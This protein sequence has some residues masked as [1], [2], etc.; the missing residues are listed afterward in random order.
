MKVII[1]R[2]A[3]TV[4]NS[5][6]IHI[7]NDTDPL[8][9]EEGKKQAEKL[10]HLLKTEKIHFAYVSPQKRAVHTAE[11]VLKFHPWAKM[12]QM[13]HLRE[14]RLGIYESLPKHEWKKIKENTKDPFHLFKPPQ[15]ESYTEL[16]ARVAE[17]FNDLVNKHENDTVFIVSHR[18][19]LGMLYLHLFNK[20]ITEDNYNAHKPENTALT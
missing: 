8:L 3:E 14:Q 4:E 19:T 2:H 5:K 15:G 7:G 20:P 13:P 11:K 10:A 6:K 17:F 1:T 9:S 18:G 12:V 16:R